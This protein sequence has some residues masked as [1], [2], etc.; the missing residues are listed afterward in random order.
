MPTEIKGKV[1]ILNCTSSEFDQQALNIAVAAPGEGGISN[2]V[3]VK[4]TEE[5]KVYRLWDGPDSEKIARTG[6]TNQYGAW[7]SLGTPHGTRDQYRN[8]AAICKRWNDLKW[9][10]LCTVKRGAII[11]VG[12]T[13]SVSEDK[14]RDPNKPE[15]KPDHYSENLTSQIYI[16]NYL[17]Y[18]NCEKRYSANPDNIQPP[19]DN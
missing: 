8:E 6:V 14:C 19:P 16:D 18:V 3:E 12:P 4:T 11:V 15:I 7:W 17:K 13:Q 5:I 9:A 1:E 2:G 10:A